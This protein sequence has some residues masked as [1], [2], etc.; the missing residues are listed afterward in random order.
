MDI[1]PGIFEE[2][3]DRWFRKEG[4][5][6]LVPGEAYE[7]RL[8]ERVSIFVWKEP[9]KWTVYRVSHHPDG[10]KRFEKT[11]KEFSPTDGR[12]FSKYVK[13][14]IQSQENRKKKFLKG[15]KAIDKYKAG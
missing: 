9:G 12:G 13:W 15:K 3:I 8:Y 11:L 1:N 6:V 5:L 7:Y 10:K 4:F 14:Y 2:K